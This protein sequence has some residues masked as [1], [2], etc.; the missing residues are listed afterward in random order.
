MFS[1]FFSLEPEKQERIVN[2]ATKEFAKKG[3]DAASTNEIVR[4]ANIGKGMLFH[5]FNSKKELFLFLYDYSLEVV[6]KEFFGKINLLERDILVRW[7]Q[8]SMLK[9]E[10]VRKYPDI[11]NFIMT[12]NLE[13][14]RAVADS[15]GDRNKE[16]VTLSLNK[17]FEDIDTS[18]FKEGVD[19]KKAGKVILWAIEGISAEA[20]EK[21]KK[22]SLQELDYDEILEEVDGY[23]E[24]FRNCFYKQKRR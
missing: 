3:F 14:S 13:G 17:I 2:A 9:I 18:K 4:E 19:I 5:Y 12:A 16:F 20:G 15:L 22:L 1:K 8:I 7:K 21:A 24:L 10:L 11:L 6:R 23:L